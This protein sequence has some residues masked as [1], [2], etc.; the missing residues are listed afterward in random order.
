[1][2]DS[3]GKNIRR[4]T[5]NKS[6]ETSPSWSPDGR[7]LVFSSDALGKPQ[8]YEIS[9]SGGPTRRIPTNISSYCSEPVWNPVDENL[10][11]FTTAEHGGFQ[12]TLR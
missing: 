12:I 10:I 4:L 6:L 1:M 11:A 8:L 5:T 9:S 7:R 2:S 3:R